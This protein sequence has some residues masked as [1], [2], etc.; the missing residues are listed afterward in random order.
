[1]RNG[2][3]WV[4]AQRAANRAKTS[5]LASVDG[6]R[7]AQSTQPVGRGMAGMHPTRAPRLCRTPPRGFLI[8]NVN[9]FP[10]ERLEYE[11]S[12]DIQKNKN[13]ISGSGVYSE[14]MPSEL[15]RIG[16]SSRFNL[17]SE[18]L[19]ARSQFRAVLCTTSPPIALPFS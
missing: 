10:F 3:C 4:N 17:H 5:G 12:A 1:M 15:N 2:A 7:Q 14:Q 9:V 18:R 11:P 6:S 8:D 19:A 16:K 13:I